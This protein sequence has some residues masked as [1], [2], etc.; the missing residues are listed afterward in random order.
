[1]DC[2]EASALMPLSL[3]GELDARSARA[4]D[5]H[6]AGCTACAERQRQLGA[7]TAAMRA[8][9][10]YRSAP[11]SL[12]R[13]VMA[14][15]AAAT[16]AAP[17]VELERRSPAARTRLGWPLLAGAG[18]AAAACLALAMLLPQQPQSASQRLADELVS[19]HARALLSGHL[20]DVASSDQHTVKPW[21]GG[22]LDFSP[23]VRDLAEQGFPLV[24]GRLDYVGHRQTAVLVYRR[25]QHLIDVFVVPA[26]AVAA[27]SPASSAE[28]FNILE[29]TA[30]GM[31][32]RAV[33]D[34]DA[35]DLQQLAALF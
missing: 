2:R 12:R 27:P 20:V 11:E 9:A 17:K 29:W 8:T 32:L 19:S 25:R 15:L 21:F 3:D 31:R 5:D 4:L 30:A 14:S 24:G 7:T 10:S 18:W 26:D 33:S 16:A 34:V 1:M 28:G 22:K 13:N 23:P 6:V 35:A